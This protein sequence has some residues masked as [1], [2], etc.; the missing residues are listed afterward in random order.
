MDTDG[1]GRE[2]YST[3]EVAKLLCR[4]VPTIKR[5]KREGKFPQALINNGRTVLWTKDQLRGWIRE[6]SDESEA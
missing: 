3:K 4:S 5:W 2:C 1:D 6:S